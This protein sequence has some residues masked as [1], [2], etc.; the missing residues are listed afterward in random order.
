MSLPE[1]VAAKLGTYM[2]ACRELLSRFS[3]L[4][5]ATVNDNRLSEIDCIKRFDEVMHDFFSRSTVH[6]I[7]KAVERFCDRLEVESRDIRD[8]NT[9]AAKIFDEIVTETAAKAKSWDYM[10]DLE[11]FHSQARELA[12]LFFSGSTSP[13]TQSRLV[14]ACNIEVDY[15][16]SSDGRDVCAESFGF[17]LAP[18]ACY[19][20][21]AYEGQSA[22]KIKVRFNFDHN[23][24]SYLSYIFLFLHEYT[25][26]IYSTDYGNERFNDGWMLHAASSFLFQ[27]QNS[28]KRQIMIDDQSGIFEARLRGFVNPIPRRASM[29][30]REFEV[31]ICRN[32]PERFLEITHQLAGFEP[33]DRE[34]VFWPNQF[35]NAL[36]IEFLKDRQRLKGL[37]EES[38]DIRELMNKLHFRG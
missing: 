12:Q 1:G 7:A 8:M 34:N 17:R 24:S 25:A 35:I 30:A 19:P 27:M 22:T 14:T 3:T 11:S 29:F 13:A 2:L 18:V 5:L 15:V 4:K 37:V 31:I 33:Q 20:Y 26:H 28:A 9:E 32:F 21:E 16:T 10:A 6:D 36:E 38:T 23:F